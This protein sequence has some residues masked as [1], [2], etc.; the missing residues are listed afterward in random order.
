M[1]NGHVK[2]CQKILSRFGKIA[3]KPWRGG[4]SHCSLV[5][6]YRWT[7][8]SGQLAWSK[9]RQ[10]SALFLQSSREPGELSQ[11]FEQDDSTVNIIVVITGT[12][13]PI[14]RGTGGLFTIDFFVCVYLCF[15]VS[16]ITRKRLDRFARNF[17]G[18]CG[19][20]MERRDLIFDQFRET[21]RCRDAQNG[22][23]VCCAFAPQRVP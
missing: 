7:S 12:P 22:D 17:Q 18:R 13:S 11:C 14:H 8:S 3:T 9:G 4:Y 5:A 1:H 19:V 6:A 15:F 23:G 20:T 2:F 10:S 21:A 16:K